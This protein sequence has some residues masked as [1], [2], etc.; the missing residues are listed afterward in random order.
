MRGARRGPSR[1]T[2]ITAAKSD[3]PSCSSSS[4]LT[5][6]AA[7]ALE[8]CKP[9][10]TRLASGSSSAKSMS[11]SAYLSGKAGAYELD[12][13]AGPLSLT[14]GLAIAPLSSTACT[15][16]APSPSFSA[17]TRPSPSAASCVPMTRFTTS[18]ILV[19]SPT[20]S[21]TK[22][23]SLP[24]A[25]RSDCATSKTPRSPAAIKMSA[26]AAAGPLL[27]LT[28]ASR[29]APPRA[30]TRSANETMS[31]GCRV[32]QSMICLPSRTP[33][34]TPPLI[35]YTSSHAAGVES[36]RNVR[37]H[38][39][40]TAAGDASIVTVPGAAAALNRSDTA[41]LRV[42]TLSGTPACSSWFAMPSPMIPRPMKPRGAEAHAM[43]RSAR[44]MANLS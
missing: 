29:K 18:F 44:P 3:S 40:M 34:S 1:D 30:R 24:I 13:M 8:T 22:T 6:A 27:P 11:L 12:A 43:I 35:V 41:R 7:A 26:P 33:S 17:S 20:V 21:L 25:P 5:N 42:H 31:P 23:F 4:A 38:A 37:S 28:G 19:A 39:E 36:M 32:A 14:I 10:A 15:F 16:S 9:P 2:S